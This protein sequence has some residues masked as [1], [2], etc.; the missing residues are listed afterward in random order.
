[1]ARRND[2][3]R[4]WDYVG[5][6]DSDKCWLWRG[7]LHN[8]RGYG[9]TLNVYDGKRYRLAHQYA[10]AVFYEKHA[11]YVLHTCDR[12]SCVNPLHLRSAT[13]LENMRDAA[14][15]GRLKARAKITARDVLEIRG[16]RGQV[17]AQTLAE[18]FDL[19]PQN[20]RAIWR[21]AKWAHI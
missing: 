18:R 20:I 13:H 21:R 7:G 16:L 9:A 3:K 5:I 10:F 11:R 14:S 17:P 4:F 1:M 8:K 15:K 6:D 19:H 2:A 12:P